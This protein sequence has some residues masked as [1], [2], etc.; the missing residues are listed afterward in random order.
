MSKTSLIP[1]EWRIVK[2]QNIAEIQTGISISSSR[3]LQDPINVP[4]LRVANVQ[5]GY[6]DLAVIKNVSIERSKLSRFQLQKGDVLL[7]EGG[8]FDKLGRGAVWTGEITK[9]V[10]Q[11]HIFAVR[12]NKDFLLPEFLSLL[13]SSSYGK[14]YFISC[15]KQSTNL[16]SI[17]SKQ[18]K[19]FP[20]LL[21]N[22]NTQKEIISKISIFNNAMEKTEALIAVKEK[23][24]EWLI[25]NLIIKSINNRWNL[26]KLSNLTKIQK[27]QQL[28]RILL[29]KTNLFPAWNGGITPSGYTDTWNTSENTVTISEGG[30]SCGF[31]NYCQ[32]KFWCGGHCYALLDISRE[33]ESEFLFYFLKAHEKQIMNLRVGS[34][35]PNIQRR[36]I[37]NIEIAY[38]QLSEQRKIVQILSNAQKE[39][40]ILNL[41][42]NKYTNQKF[43]LMQKLLTG[44]WH[45]KNREVEPA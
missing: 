22:I 40:S 28:N 6:L 16:A 23:Q 17:N 2:L 39:I 20:V 45:I 24:F 37:E 38:P 4:Y 8:D 29:T 31:V 42:I 19:Q 15:S 18:L 27:G 32:E 7:T 5:D 10:H 11:N 21:P 1:G 25:D 12:P 30:N 13:T 26:R 14:R 9:C 44:E 36:D 33:I 3:Q 34:G 43:G 41:L 35:L